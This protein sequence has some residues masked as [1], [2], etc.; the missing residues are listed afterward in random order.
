MKTYKYYF[1]KSQQHP[2]WRLKACLCFV[3]CLTRAFLQTSSAVEAGFPLGWG[4]GGGS[5]KRGGWGAREIKSRRQSLRN[6]DLALRRNLTGPDRVAGYGS[7]EIGVLCQGPGRPSLPDGH[8]AA[9]T[10][11]DLEQS[12][13]CS[14]AS[15]SPPP[16]PSPHS[17]FASRPLE[18]V[19]FALGM[20]SVSWG[21][22][23]GMG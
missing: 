4:D 14:C 18:V 3:F 20:G 23:W 7:R 13:C 1:K 8:A 10:H 11:W 6:P 12:C 22:R 16:P 15:P 19:V 17:K 21:L 9:N 5:G 2:S